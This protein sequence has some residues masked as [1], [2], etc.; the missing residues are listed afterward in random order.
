MK[1]VSNWI[2]Y[3]HA[4]FWIFSPP[5]AILFNFLNSK[6]DLEFP[7]FLFHFHHESGEAPMVKVVHLFKTCWPIF[8]LEFFEPWKLVFGANQ[9]ELEF[10]S[11]SIKISV[12]ARVQPRCHRASPAPPRCVHQ[13][14]PS[15]PSLPLIYKSQVSPSV[16]IFPHR[17]ELPH[18]PIFPPRKAT[19]TSPA[20][21]HFLPKFLPVIGFDPLLLPPMQVSASTARRST[22]S[23]P[24]PLPLSRALSSS[25][26]SGEPRTTSLRH[27]IEP[28]AAPLARGADTLLPR[29]RQRRC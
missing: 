27:K 4:N 23:T 20:P 9:L 12:G 18:R 16:S 28:P 14:C 6:I 1:S 26:Q 21:L 5:L 3:L 11:V 29:H 2:L 15:S 17:Q 25:T 13:S 8:L 7:N 10:N 19:P 22:A 24:H